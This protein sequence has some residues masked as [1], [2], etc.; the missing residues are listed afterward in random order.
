MNTILE[1][2]GNESARNEWAGLL[3]QQKNDKKLRFSCYTPSAQVKNIKTCLF[4][5]ETSSLQLFTLF[6]AASSVM[7]LSSNV[8]TKD[9]VDQFD[10]FR[11]HHPA[12]GIVQ[13]LI[14]SLAYM[15]SIQE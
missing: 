5:L 6:H 13:R 3:L 15:F 9:R 7:L 10:L 8:E 2:E 11:T 4:L 14:T 12:S 1:G